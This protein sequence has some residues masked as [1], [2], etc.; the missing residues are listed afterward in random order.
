M[1]VCTYVCMY[2]C[3]Y[4]CLLAC[5]RACVR[6]CMYVCTY[7]RT[8]ARTHVR[9][10]VCLCDY[11]RDHGLAERERA[12]CT[13]PLS[14]PFACSHAQYFSL[15]GKELATSKPF[16]RARLGL[17][18]DGDFII[19]VDDCRLSLFI[20]STAV[21]QRTAQSIAGSNVMYATAW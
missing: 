4:V 16:T 13:R 7:V 12:A 10:Y 20:S 14:T 6:T 9:M 21:R 11:R 1:S 2:V 15:G 5:V 8:H 17:V 3:M 18:G 19:L